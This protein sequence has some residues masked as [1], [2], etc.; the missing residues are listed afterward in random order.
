MAETPLSPSATTS[1]GE[2][3]RRYR[4]AAGL[5]QEALADRTGLSTRGISDLECGRRSW[6]R[7]ETVRLLLTGLRLPE[8]ESAAF[9]RAA[10]RRSTPRRSTA[11]GATPV[12]NGAKQPASAFALSVLP[13]V[14]RDEELRTLA[15]LLA[16]PGTRLLTL[17]GAGGS[18]KTRLA[19][20]IG[21]QITDTFPDGVFFIDL[22]PVNDPAL[23]LA[24]LAGALDVQEAGSQ[25]LECTLIAQLQQQRVLV[26]LDNCEHLLPFGSELLT[27]LAACP[28]L[29]VLA[30]SRQRLNLRLEQ[31]MLVPPLPLPDLSSDLSLAELATN[32][33]VTLFLQRAVRSR[34]D[35]SL[36]TD[37]AAAVAGV[38]H[39]LDGL[40][41]AIELAAAHM[42]VMSPGALLARL[43]HRLPL[44]TGGPA[45]APARQRTLRDTIAWS[46][47]LLTGEEQAL[48]ARLA[49]FAGGWSLSAAEA[50]ANA[51]DD[52]DIF[53]SL[54]GLVDKNLIYSTVAPSDEPRFAMLTA[55]R[56]FA[57]EHAVARGEAARLRVAH[58]WHFLEQAEAT[59]A[60]RANCT[61]P[62]LERGQTDHD[63]LRTALATFIAEN[64]ADAA[65][66]LAGALGRFWYHRGFWSEGRGWL[67]RVLALPDEPSPLAKA[68]T[69]VWFGILAYYQGDDARALPAIRESLSLSQAHG[70]FTAAAFAR[71]MLAE[72][73]VDAEAY[74]SAVNDL[75]ATLPFYR[76]RGDREWEA[77][78]LWLLGRALSGLGENGLAKAMCDDALALYQELD[79]A[80]GKTVVHAELGANA[81]ERRYSPRAA[82]HLRMALSGIRLLGS[83]HD[84]RTAL[85]SVAAL[86]AAHGELERAARL[87]GAVAAA[88]E[89]LGYRVR[90]AEQARTQRT[91]AMLRGTL[92]EET[93]TRA[94]HAGMNLTLDQAAAEALALTEP[95]AAA[96]S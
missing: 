52:A 34:L 18:G 21:K 15:G 14:G 38:C 64:D 2:A 62:G 57:W 16:D 94:W 46:H 10:R 24:A 73:A 31:E 36:T 56:E 20:E 71:F 58:A 47:G 51:M 53:E 77:N 3:L 5:T 45:D 12:M 74:E 13:F 79:N 84:L 50:V 43:D 42:K 70:D 63:N 30:T 41:L 26:I 11:T 19:I 27:I 90:Q 87:F 75:N 25:P 86:A 59:E 54:M 66:R 78:A 88:D 6:P 55:I 81:C 35:F 91:L 37:N 22:A 67:E 8:A 95:F 83:V 82:S 65:H 9:V 32:P 39:R 48:L 33:A 60:R 29:T 44:L 28:G 40:P 80:W 4:V 89:R 68:R 49:V 96:M 93:F 85:S 7:N 1:F 17:T 23:L 72:V 69:L 92:S 61:L 76:A